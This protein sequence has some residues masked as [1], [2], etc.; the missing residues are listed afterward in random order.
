MSIHVA[1][2][3]M[4]ARLGD[5]RS[6]L[7]TMKDFVR[8]IRKEKPETD[9]IL[10]PEC[11]L[12][13]YECPDLIPPLAEF[14]PDGNGIRSVREMAS[15]SGVFIAFG[16][17]EIGEDGAIYNSAG[18]ID[19]H[20]DP[21]GIYRKAHLLDGME[22]SLY[23]AGEQFPVFETEIGRIGMMVCWDSVFPEAARMLSIH[24]AELILVPEAVEKGIEREWDLALSAR[25]F[26]NGTFILSSNHIGKDRDL[27]YFGR[28]ALISPSGQIVKQLDDTQGYF[29]E[30]VDYL[31]V[32]EQR[33]YFYMLKNLRTNIYRY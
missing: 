18:L 33:E 12:T 4:E 17:P 23:K 24:G 13:G 15:E 7:E 8:R 1:S 28:S 21:V 2:V 22:S 25:A 19:R 26:D 5:V 6:N 31:R 3:Q 10:F 16:F 9:L 27:D 29:S 14:W 32:R 30:T 20:G 11:V